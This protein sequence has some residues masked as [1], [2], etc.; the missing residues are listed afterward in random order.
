MTLRLSD[1]GYVYGGGTGFAHRA[2]DGVSLDLE[3]GE[4]VLVL[5]PTGSGKSTLLRVAA[6]LLPASDGS[7]VLNGRPVDGPVFGFAGGVGLAFQSPESQLFAER[8]VD[9]VAF[10]P[11]NQ[12]MT[13][14]E[15]ADAAR[16]AIEAVGLPFEE[17]AERSPFTLSGGE[18]RRVAL[19]GVLAMRPSHLLLDEPTSGLDASGR[20]A[21]RAAVMAARRHAGLLVVTH[22]AEEFL[23]VS[24]RVLILD[25]GHT[26]YYGPTGTLLS[27]PS[28]FA[29]AGLRPPEVL[30]TQVLA[31]D[32]G[33]AVTGFTLDPALAAQRLFAA[34]ER[35]LADGGAT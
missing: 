16:E 32:T 21:V 20:A 10:G 28:P 29:M 2:L 3:V 26:V 7:V 4:L 5:G 18:A 14:P 9:D 25:Q 27:D 17:F 1:I 8:I 30:Q 34:H 33:F 6:G 35:R 12:G 19:A 22:D 31:R 11:R 23:G 13:Q 24:D 15:A